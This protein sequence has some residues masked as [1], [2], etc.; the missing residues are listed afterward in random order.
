MMGRCPNSLYPSRKNGG[1]AIK[2]ILVMKRKEMM[3][4][5]ILFLEENF[6]YRN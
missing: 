4:Q 6:S 3:D 2:I 1:L 5:K